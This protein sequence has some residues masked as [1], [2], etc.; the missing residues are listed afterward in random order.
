MSGEQ[1]HISFTADKNLWKE[2][3]KKA[4]DEDTTMKDL[5]IAA[6]RE[7]YEINP[8]GAPSLSK[9]DSKDLG[10]GSELYNLDG[11]DLCSDEHMVYVVL[12]AA[13]FLKTNGTA[14]KEDFIKYVYPDFREDFKQDSWWKAAKSGLKQMSELTD[15]IETPT[16]KGHSKYKWLGD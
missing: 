2:L 5:I 14:K 7:K 15:K 11:G 12:A 10:F 16:G 9:N 3:K 4:I 13:N 8:I 1:K 6:I